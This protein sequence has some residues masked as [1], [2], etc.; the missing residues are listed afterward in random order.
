MKI[1][2]IENM[3]KPDNSEV[4]M[5]DSEKY[6]YAYIIVGFVKSKKF[7]EELV[8]KYFKCEVNYSWYE[9][10]SVEEVINF[11]VKTNQI[12]IINVGKERNSKK[13]L[14]L[15]L[16]IAKARIDTLSDRRIASLD[17]ELNQWGLDFNAIKAEG[18]GL[19]MG[20][21]KG[22]IITWTDLVV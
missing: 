17:N 21:L 12:I 7:L 5:L 18:K 19:R 8:R 15:M 2:I 11:A 20:I 3:K 22:R 16:F 13:E 6:K 10:D 9:S 14:E 4:S 1:E